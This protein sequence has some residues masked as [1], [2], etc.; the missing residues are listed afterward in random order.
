MRPSVTKLKPALAID[1]STASYTEYLESPIFNEFNRLDGKYFEEI[2]PK[3]NIL[4]QKIQGLLKDLRKGNL[5][6]D[7]D[8]KLTSLSEAQ[9]ECS[10]FIKELREY[11]LKHPHEQKKVAKLIS[12]LRRLYTQTYSLSLTP[13]WTSA[14]KQYKDS[15][16]AEQELD[17]TSQIIEEALDFEVQADTPVKAQSQLLPEAARNVDVPFTESER[18][19]FSEHFAQVR[20]KIHGDYVEAA[21]VIEALTPETENMTYSEYRAHEDVKIRERLVEATRTLDAIRD[22]IEEVQ[23]KKAEVPKE[24]DQSERIFT[25]AQFSEVEETTEDT[26]DVAKRLI[27]ARIEP[28]LAELLRKI[29]TIT[30]SNKEKL[31]TA[32]TLHG[33]LRKCADAYYINGDPRLKGKQEAFIQSCN[34]HISTAMKI[35]SKEPGWG[36]YLIT[37]AKQLA[38]ALVRCVTLGHRHGFFTI[39]ANIPQA[40]ETFKQDARIQELQEINSNSPEESEESDDTYIV[41]GSGCY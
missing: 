9:K 30:Q 10:L 38:N 13:R 29:N 25:I 3:V 17:S 39:P 18:V 32:L 28:A 2:A 8:K 21:R 7:I 33:E 34:G 1:L 19:A 5:T 4:K 11:S 35:L 14:I 37:L 22:I 16:P 20:A 6:I 41:L 36:E 31:Q 12:D 24:E 40:L 15:L 26:A 27:A 23:A